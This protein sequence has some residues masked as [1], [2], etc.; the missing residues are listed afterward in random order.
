MDVDAAAESALAGTRDDDGPKRVVGCQVMRR[1]AD[2]LD[3][4]FDPALLVPTAIPSRLRRGC[5]AS[6]SSPM[7]TPGRETG[8][9]FAKT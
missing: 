6:R 5:V 1:L 3:I 4:R 7:A 8:H 2:F 9:A